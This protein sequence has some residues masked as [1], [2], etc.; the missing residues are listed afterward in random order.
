M[1]GTEFIGFSPN[2]KNFQLAWEFGMYICDEPQLE[3]W[4]KTLGRFNA[5]DAAIAKV[6]DPL[7]AI[8]YEAAKSGL[9]ERP[10]HFVE[11]Y[12]G[13][14]Y[15]VLQDNLAQITSGVFTPEAG[16][17]DLIIQLNKAIASQ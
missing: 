8:T 4:G 17:A 1:K 5:N 11:A 14:Y 16:A 12:P 2:S 3:R 15:Q 6:T 9:L 7:L 13:N 10:P